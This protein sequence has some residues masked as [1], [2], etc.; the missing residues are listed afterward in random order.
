MSG[1]LK[2]RTE[3]EL[4]FTL[5]PP[6]TYDEAL[7]R[8]ANLIDEVD[9]AQDILS[10]RLDPDSRAFWLKTLRIKRSLLRQL[11]EW[12]R[13]NDRLKMSE[14]ELL[15]RTHRLLTRMGT[16]APVGYHEEM[17]ALLDAIELVVPGQYL[18]KAE[19][20]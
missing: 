8:R 11:K 14:W 1:R 17:E 20:R 10:G 15:A 2:R 9:A 4:D 12:L 13:K 5:E 18:E 19:R 3:V 16:E 6:K 7:L